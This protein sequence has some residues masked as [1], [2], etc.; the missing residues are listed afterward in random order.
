[1]MTVYKRL[2]EL[3]DINMGQSPA[4]ESYNEV[5]D[6]LPFFQGNADFGELYPTTRI[7]CNAPTK[8]VEPGTILISVRAPIGALNYSDKTCCIG[9]GLA[10]ISSKKGVESKYIYYCLKSKNRELNLKG[11]GSTFKAIAKSAL[12]GTEVKLVSEKEQKQ[13]VYTLDAV[14]KTIKLRKQQLSEL[15]NLIKSR[16][17]EMFG[18]IYDTNVKWETDLLKNLLTIE[19]GGSPRPIDQYITQDE[20]GV[21]W[22]KIGDTRD[23]SIYIDTCKEKI[24]PEGMKKSRYVSK[25]DLL[26]SNSMSFGRP[27]ILNIDGC[28]HDGWLVLK[29]EKNIF[30]KIFLCYLLGSNETYN[31]FKAMAEGGVVSNL[32]KE[33]VGK[34]RVTIPN[35]LLQDEFSHFVEQVDKSKFDVQKSIEELQTLYDSLMQKYFG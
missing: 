18:S 35:R 32:N 15:D 8:I 3:C 12:G 28:I 21:N 23:N 13:I 17:V 10:G 26:L 24:K 20:N 14:S 34:L 30:D 33:L 19:R 29:D 5:G 25:G 27:Y 2:D 9:R 4:S 16:F 1:M 6:G 7:W 11:T 31:M 22:I